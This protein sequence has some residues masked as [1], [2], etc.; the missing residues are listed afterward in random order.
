MY[1]RRTPSTLFQQGKFVR[2][3]IGRYVIYVEIRVT[4]NFSICRQIMAIKENEVYLM[5]YKIIRT[6]VKKLS[7]CSNFILYGQM[8]VFTPSFHKSIQCDLFCL[9]SN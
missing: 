6:K 8:H 7:E 1:T 5:L 2:I 4:G 9:Q 3:P